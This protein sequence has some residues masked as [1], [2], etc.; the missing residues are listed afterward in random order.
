MKNCEYCGESCNSN[1]QLNNKTACPSCNLE[2]GFARIL[3][4]EMNFTINQINEIYEK[5]FM[6]ESKFIYSTKKGHLTASIK[7]QINRGEDMGR[8]NKLVG[9]TINSKY[10]YDCNAFYVEYLGEKKKK[11]PIC[12]SILKNS[13]IT[14][15]K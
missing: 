12:K 13:I 14:I 9:R 15:R 7:K 11:C 3:F 8:I 6:G 1:I 5:F 4:S 2:I 10:C